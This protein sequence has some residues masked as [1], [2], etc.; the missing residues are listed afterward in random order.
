[1]VPLSTLAGHGH[2]LERTLLCAYG[3]QRFFCGSLA[4]L[5]CNLELGYPLTKA[6]L[7]AL[8]IAQLCTPL[9]VASPQLRWVLP[10]HAQTYSR[11]LYR[12]STS[13]AFNS[14]RNAD[15]L[16]GPALGGAIP[17]KAPKHGS[18]LLR[19]RFE[20]QPVIRVAPS[21]LER[22]PT[23]E[24]KLVALIDTGVNAKGY[25]MRS[26]QFY[27]TGVIWCLGLTLFT[28]L[29]PYYLFYGFTFVFGY[30]CLFMLFLGLRF[31]IV[32]LWRLVPY[33]RRLTLWV[34]SRF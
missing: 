21:Q 12:S 1:L 15:Y 22:L 26:R 7:L 5:H 14:S 9:N 32:G 11:A 8:N 4:H 20:S 13:M 31:V 10:S 19:G 18:S 2:Y 34:R 23:P 30:Y 6:E 24:Y 16:S 3:L 27:R 33:V 29:G 28:L 25:T 17:S